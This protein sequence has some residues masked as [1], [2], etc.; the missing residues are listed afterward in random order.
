MEGYLRVRN[1]RVQCTIGV[2]ES[3]KQE[4]QEILVDLVCRTD[5]SECVQT[6]S[7]A[8]TVDYSQ[9]AKVLEEVAQAEHF[10]LL[11]TY[12]HEALH[13]LFSQFP[14]RWG[15][16]RVKKKSALPLADYVAVELEKEA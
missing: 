7:I 16:I 8:D 9:M 11:E 14:L 10:N 4:K 3:E 2:L 5:F 13:A 15:K 1:L 6:D 12:A